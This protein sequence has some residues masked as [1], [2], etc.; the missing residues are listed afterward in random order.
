MA[1][2]VFNQ[3]RYV[4]Q[5]IRSVLSQTY[6]N[7]ELV[8]ADDG[9]TDGT[10]RILKG[11]SDRRLRVLPGDRNL[12][13]ATRMNQIL[14]MARGRY[15]LEMDGDDWLER[16]S[17]AVLVAR[18]NRL[19]RSVALLYGDRRFYWQ[20]R[21][22]PRFL[23]IRRGRAFRGRASF[24]RRPFVGGPRF[25][26]VSAL[27]DVGGWPTDYPSRGRLAED[28][29]LLLRLV[30]HYD[31]QHIGRV[32]YNIRRHGRNTTVRFRPRFGPIVSF[33]IRRARRRAG[34]PAFFSGAR[35]V[36]GATA[37]RAGN[38]ARPR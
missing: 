18:M 25:Y 15:L 17:V 34:M 27:R 29:A 30:Q 14:K 28:L 22:G 9:S 33:L 3:A 23:R 38:S 37:K 5:A 10:A 32:L 4:A 35:R 19:P 2:T 8:V 6:R 16:D 24:L 13:K 7:L 31:F 26:R 21:R 1:V 11:F 12:G 20:T 36:R